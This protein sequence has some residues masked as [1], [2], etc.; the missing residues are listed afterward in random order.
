M[1]EHDKDNPVEARVQAGPSIL[2]HTVGKLAK[3]TREIVDVSFPGFDG[4]IV[5][6]CVFIRDQPPF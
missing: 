2:G 4:Y 5:A 6:S 3:L 1:K